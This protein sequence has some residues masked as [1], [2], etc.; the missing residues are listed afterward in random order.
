MRSSAS[1]QSMQ[2][3][4]GQSIGSNVVKTNDSVSRSHSRASRATRRNSD[5][6]L[7]QLQKA[8]DVDSG[9][10]SESEHKSFTS[11]HRSNTMAPRKD[12]KQNLKNQPLNTPSNKRQNTVAVPS[13]LKKDGSQRKVEGLQRAASG[14]SPSHGQSKH[15]QAASFKKH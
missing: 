3:R 9:K 11:R 1:R 15:G 6:S 4:V 12:E 14:Q 10:L 7:I 13:D 5:K 8:S 2:K